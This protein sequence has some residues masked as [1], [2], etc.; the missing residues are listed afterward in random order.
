[1]EITGK[2]HPFIGKYKVSVNVLKDKQMSSSMKN[3]SIAHVRPLSGLSPFLS[4]QFDNS[5][6]LTRYRWW[7]SLR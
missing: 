5:L 6:L 4:A 2:R 7:Q 1:M 3:Q